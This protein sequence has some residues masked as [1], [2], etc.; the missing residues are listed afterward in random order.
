M[1]CGWQQKSSGKLDISGDR[2]AQF[3]PSV[4]GKIKVMDGIEIRNKV[5]DTDWIS[6][7]TTSFNVYFVDLFANILSTSNGV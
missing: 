2:H 7:C 6:L 1:E 4:H 3:R 5:V